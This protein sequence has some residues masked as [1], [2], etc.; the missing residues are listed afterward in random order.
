MKEEVREYM[1]ENVLPRVKNFLDGLEGS[2]SDEIKRANEEVLRRRVFLRKL[3]K[4]TKELRD[5][6]GL[7]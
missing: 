3:L 2:L 6:L 4:E 5:F 1:E 7:A